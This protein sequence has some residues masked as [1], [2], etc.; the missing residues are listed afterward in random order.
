MSIQA[1]RTDACAETA[2]RQKRL[3][4]ILGRAVLW[5]PA[6]EAGR[7]LAHLA[8]VACSQCPG[9]ELR[10]RRPDHAEARP[11]TRFRMMRGCAC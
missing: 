7:A 10:F 11:I 2:T 8:S 4:D 6:E 5:R 9:S 3:F 1:A